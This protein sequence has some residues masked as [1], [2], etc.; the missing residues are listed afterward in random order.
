MTLNF[1]LSSRFTSDRKKLK[2]GHNVVW[3][4]TKHYFFCSVM[5][6]INARKRFQGENLRVQ[7]EKQLKVLKKITKCLRFYLL[8]LLRKPQKSHGIT[9]FQEHGAATRFLVTP[10][11]CVTP[12]SNT[13]VMEG[14]GVCSFQNIFISLV[15][16][17]PCSCCNCPVALHK[18]FFVASFLYKITIVD[19]GVSAHITGL[20]DNRKENTGVLAFQTLFFNYPKARRPFYFSKYSGL[21][22]SRPEV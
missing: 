1:S 20:R 4:A 5:P 12:F 18:I 3:F 9:H 17:V 19:L 22:I 14:K 21:E 6:G 7:G 11:H 16:S 8:G 2:R 10:S 13:P 15:F